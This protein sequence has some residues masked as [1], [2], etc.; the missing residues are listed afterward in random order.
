M[1]KL[2][3][4]I[5]RIVDY[6]YETIRIKGHSINPDDFTIIAGPCTIENRESLEEIA[7]HLNSIGI[8]FMR[9]GAYKLRT[10]PQDFAGLGSI[11]FDWL[12]TI[13]EKYNLV[14]VS[15]ITDSSHLDE[16][17]EKVD[18]LLVGTRNML[19]YPLLTQ[20]GKSGKPVILKRGMSSTVEEW[21]LASEYILSE[22]NSRLIYCERGIRTF[23]S[24]TRNTYDISAIP[25]LRKYIP[26]PIIGDPSHATGLRELIKP[27]SLATVAAGASGLLIEAHPTPELVKVDSRQTIDLKTLTEI[28]QLSG[29]IKKILY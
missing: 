24:I 20:I 15:E 21:L 1:K 28:N 10:S 11:A 3:K 16:M 23:D 13:S 6:K 9:G 26:F 12:G 29:E 17:M 25:L 22:G 4:I 14:T 8:N 5:E 19:N 18:I 7:L 27:V 2:E